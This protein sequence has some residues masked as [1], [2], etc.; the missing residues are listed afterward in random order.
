MAP[1]EHSEYLERIANTKSRMAEAGIEVLLVS[2]PANMNYLTGY[3]GWSFYVH[4]MVIVAL[5][6]D[7]PIWVGRGQDASGARLSSF[8]A[9][10]NIRGYADDYV[11]STVKHPMQYVAEV[12]REAGWAGRAM[13]LEMDAYYFTAR[14][15]H[16]LTRA[17]PEATFRDAD[18]LV[19]WV[20]V[21]KS[22][23]EIGYMREAGKIAERAMQAAL[24]AIAPGVRECD[25]VA[26]IAAAQISGT[27]D[28]GGDYPAIVPLL[29]SGPKAAAPHLTWS[30]AR[31]QSDQGTIIELAG[32]RHRYHAPLARTVYLGRP[33]EA[34]RDTAQVVVEGLNAALEAA[35]PGATCEEVEA[36]WRRV[37]AKSGIVKE[38][39]IGYSTGLNYPPDWGEHTASL[40]PG[41]R[42]VIEPDMT[43]HLIPA[44]WMDDWGLEISESFRVTERGAETFADFPR[45]L[46][47]KP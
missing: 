40:R 24:D 23:A 8:L 28:F 7:Q 29:P 41:D 16:E 35:R 1:F 14:C 5:D 39:R 38:S 13:G 17:L 11:Q 21:V 46:I 37:I 34:V 2:N 15:H 22:A 4:Q 47:V 20:R 44:I 6:A 31:Y 45:E 32:C 43:F 19:N 30:D 33:S 3:D 10:Q 25:A 42:T 18:L 36:A 9:D 12:L 26:R 27:E